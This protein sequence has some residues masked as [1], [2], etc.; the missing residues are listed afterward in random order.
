M[1][2]NYLSIPKFQQLHRWSLGMDNNFTHSPV[3]NWGEGICNESNNPGDK[4][5]RCVSEVLTFPRIHYDDVLMGAMASQITSLT[6]VHS[7][8]YSGADQS[9]HQSSASLAFVW[10]IHRG[11][12]NSPHKWP[13]TRKMFPFDDV[14][15]FIFY[16]GL[17]LLRHAHGRFC[18]VDFTSYNTYWSCEADHW[19]AMLNT[20]LVH[21]W[22]N[23]ATFVAVW[24]SGYHL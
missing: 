20:T 22:P 5:C 13:V 8:V 16:C 15:V 6:I 14:T 10:G 2:W 9:K 18:Q 23:R 1:R 11:P 7:T 17:M 19:Q 4:A 12:V 24:L 3:A 21:V